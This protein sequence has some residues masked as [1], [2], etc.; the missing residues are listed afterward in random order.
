MEEILRDN[1]ESSIKVKVTLYLY[2]CSLIEI[3]GLE[4]INEIEKGLVVVEIK[5]ETI[6][7]SSKFIFC[8]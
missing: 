2:I 8:Q 1:V 7:R 3:A 6:Y 5:V 4:G